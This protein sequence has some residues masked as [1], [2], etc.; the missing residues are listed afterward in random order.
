MHIG[1]IFFPVWTLALFSSEKELE[2][3]DY[4]SLPEQVGAEITETEAIN[5]SPIH[6]SGKAE[7]SA[8]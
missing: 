5:S 6:T 8:L 2:A 1:F 3:A 4:P 7:R